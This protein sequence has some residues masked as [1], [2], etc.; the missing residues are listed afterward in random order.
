ML[1]NKVNQSI[2]IKIVKESRMNEQYYYA[3]GNDEL[4]QWAAFPEAY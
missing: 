4:G 2:L 1:L 3:W